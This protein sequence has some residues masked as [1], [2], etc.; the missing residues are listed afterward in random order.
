MENTEENIDMPK[1]TYPKHKE[2]LVASKGAGFVGKGTT[3]SVMQKIKENKTAIIVMDHEEIHDGDAENINNVKRPSDQMVDDLISHSNMIVTE[4]LKVLRDNDSF[5]RF[6]NSI[7][8]HYYP[9]PSQIIKTE[10][11]IGRNQPC[12]CGSGVKYK[13]CHG[14]Q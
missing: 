7:D 8:R 3:Y 6:P 10:P 12:H 11:T 9:K 5:L 4:Q 14:K 1:G 2:V 13:K